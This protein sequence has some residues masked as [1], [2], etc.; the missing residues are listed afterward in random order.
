L[1]GE[2]VS[3]PALE[4]GVRLEP[5]HLYSM[6]QAIEEGFILDVLASYVTYKTYFRLANGL[7]S[8]DPEADKGKANAALA[9]FVALHPSNLAQKAEIIVK[10]FRAVTGNQIGGQV[11]TRSR[12]HAVC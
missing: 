12:L 5:F 8:D 2:R 3:D 6:R 11:V 9:R 7:S 4:S 10:H 1:F